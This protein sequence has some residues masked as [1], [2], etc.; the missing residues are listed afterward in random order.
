MVIHQVQPVIDS[1][2]CD[3]SN[4]MVIDSVHCKYKSHGFPCSNGEYLN[5][6]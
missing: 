1:V 5:K 2:H 6:T 3:K 4:K